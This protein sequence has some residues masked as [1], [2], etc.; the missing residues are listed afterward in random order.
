MAKHYTFSLTNDHAYDTK[1]AA[2]SIRM[3]YI[4]S[5][6][7]STRGSVAFFFSEVLFRRLVDS[8]CEKSATHNW[9]HSTY[10]ESLIKSPDVKLIRMFVY[11]KVGNS[12]IITLDL[13]SCTTFENPGVTVAT[14]DHRNRQSQEPP[15]VDA[16][17]RRGVHEA[18]AKSFTD[19]GT[20]DILA[21]DVY[22]MTDAERLAHE[23]SLFQKGRD[24]AL[25][26]A[27]GIKEN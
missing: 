18:L 26:A 20:A 10:A 14:V 15:D 7:A 5:S 4:P 19:E 27:F 12:N 25:R 21:P 6:I 16:A 2:R 3:G 11:R 13:P 23:E 17:H 8:R 1:H 22:A 9:E 24:A